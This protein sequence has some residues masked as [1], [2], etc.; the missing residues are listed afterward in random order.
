MTGL[1]QKIV[2]LEHVCQADINMHTN[3]SNAH[4]RVKQTSHTGSVLKPKLHTET[5]SLDHSA[6]KSSEYEKEIIFSKKRYFRMISDLHCDITLMT[7]K[8][9]WISMNT[10][11]NIIYAI[12][13]IFHITLCLH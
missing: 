13:H 11:C 8:V 2:L 10:V 3:T 7:L 1:F 6:S 12:Y 5:E 9:I 4:K